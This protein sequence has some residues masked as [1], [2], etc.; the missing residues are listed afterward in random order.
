MTQI[1]YFSAIVLFHFIAFLQF[2]PST[3]NGFSLK[4]VPLFS[5]ESPFNPG[6]LTQSEKIE[7]LFELSY[8][9]IKH[10]S[11]TLSHHNGSTVE[12]QK[13]ALPL[14]SVGFLFTAQIFIGSPYHEYFLAMDTGSPLV[15]T[16]CEPCIECFDQIPPR[17]DQRLSNTFS[18]LPCDDY[19]GIYS[20]VNSE[21]VNG[22]RNYTILYADGS[23]SKGIFSREKF[24]LSQNPLIEVSDIAFG[25]AKDNKGFDLG[26]TRVSGVL[27]M[28]IFG[29]DAGFGGKPYQ[30]IPIRPIPPTQGNTY[31]YNVNLIDI[32][33]G[34]NRIGFPP[35]I[36]SSPRGNTILD[37]G[38]YYAYIKSGP[39][40]VVMKKFDDYYISRGLPPVRTPH[41]GLE[42][43]Y[44]I[45]KHFK[46]FLPMTYHFEG[47]AKLKIDPPTLYYKVKGDYC[48]AILP[49][50]HDAFIGLFQQQNFRFVFD[51]NKGQIQFTPE[52]C[53][54][55]K[56]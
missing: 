37:P 1:Q 23:S 49:T 10:L 5:P 6:N 48:V 19:R 12:P 2:A 31:Q 50:D 26:D 41:E 51:L 44:H 28:N 22:Q 9:R 14:P 36:F 54:R 13:L 47:G 30:T 18:T 24:R 4:L 40:E 39:Y 42:H 20:G 45:D 11:S 27:G 8:A 55:N 32:S 38:T 35:G 7:K 15:W 29:D 25:C 21:C 34:D 43:C 33:V 17:Y 52:N 3:S 56:L 16:E 46:D 53:F